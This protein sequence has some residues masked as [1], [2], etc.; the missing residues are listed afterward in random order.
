MNSRFGAPLDAAQ[1][2]L[3]VTLVRAR[4]L[5][6]GLDCLRVRSVKHPTAVAARSN[7]IHLA[8]HPQVLRDRRLGEAYRAYT[9]L[10]RFREDLPAAEHA[11]G[12][13]AL[14]QHRPDDAPKPPH[15][16]STLR[17]RWSFT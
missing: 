15:P 14:I 10:Q 1:L 13:I 7:Q 8:Q 17:Q 11:L 12:T 2:L 4:P 5:V 16:P 9:L 3:P 6:H